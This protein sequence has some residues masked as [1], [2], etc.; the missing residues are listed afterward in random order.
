MKLSLSTRAKEAIKTALAMA[1]VY[2]IALKVSWMNP[3]WAGF[4]VA[5]VSLAA[6]GLSIQKGLLR[7]AG[8]IPGCVAALLILS[9]ASQG[10]WVFV[11]LACSWIFFTTY[12]MIVDK[13]RSYLWNV[14][15]FVCLIILLS[16]PSSSENAFNHAIYR[17]A[18]TIMGVVVYTL[19]SVFL[20]PRSNAGAIVKASVDLVTTQ[21]QIVRAARHIITGTGTRENLPQLHSQEVQQLGQLAH[22]LQAEGSESYEVQELRYLWNRLHQLSAA[23]ME[24]TDRLATGFAQLS[25][26]DASTVLPGLPAFFDELDYRFEQ[27]Q[28]VLNGDSSEPKATRRYR[29]GKPSEASGT[30]GTGPFYAVERSRLPPQVGAGKRDSSSYEIQSV[31][32]KA[33]TAALQGL[34]SL[35]RAA[36]AVGGENLKSID[37]LTRLI[38]ECVQDLKGDSVRSA[39]PGPIPGQPARRQGFALPV[40]DL[41]HLKGAT[42][43][44]FT[45]FAGFLVWILVNPPGHAGWFELSGIIAMAMAS[46]QQMNPITLGKPIA[47]ASLLCL[48]VYVFIM[49]GLSTFVGLGALLFI[50]VF[51][52]CYF[53]TG[54]ARLAGMVA[55]INEIAVQNQQSYDFAAMANS[56]VFIVS[57][58]VFLFFLS[59]LLGASRPEKALLKLSRRYFRSMEYLVSGLTPANS[60]EASWFQQWRYRAHLYEIKTLPEKIASWGRAINP[61]L[62]PANSKEQVQALVTSLEVLSIRVESL[63]EAGEDVRDQHL[64]RRTSKELLPWLVKIETTFSKWSAHPETGAG[65]INDL[66]DRLEKTLKMLETRIDRVLEQMDTTSANPVSSESYFRLLGSLRGVSEASVAYA[67]VAVGIDWGQWREEKFS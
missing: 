27:I 20:W 29:L 36:L 60:S 63:L 7:I 61:D 12:L 53:F 37:S 3:S 32:L 31:T 41:D 34:P 49:P 55:I 22:S 39:R 24:V 66:K 15:G 19:V 33:D 4:A 67:G 46:T 45:V 17:S 5:M 25:E 54:V 26:I 65:A 62:F 38:L 11:M 57:V 18:E 30:R 52:N 59:Y 28:R 48:A 8:T 9:F 6:A 43:A 2:F 23:L 13:Q 50:L 10:R 51:I 21:A 1:L 44:A 58:F 35:D 64:V 16:G 40:F 56:L 14:A 47:L 42:F